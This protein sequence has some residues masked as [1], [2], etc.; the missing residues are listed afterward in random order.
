MEK[1]FYIDIKHLDKITTNAPIGVIMEA[2][3][4]VSLT[5]I[6]KILKSDKHNVK[7]VIIY[8]YYTEN[9]IF[10]DIDNV[11]YAFYNEAEARE[12]LHNLSDKDK[13]HIL[14]AKPCTSGVEILMYKVIG[15][16]NIIISSPLINSIETLKELTHTGYKFFT[17]A[18]LNKTKDGVMDPSWIRPEGIFIYDDC[19]CNYFLTGQSN[20]IDTIV[21]GYLRENGVGFLDNYIKNLKEMGHDFEQVPNMLPITFDEMRANCGAD[22]IHCRGCKRFIDFGNNFKN[23]KES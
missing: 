8:T 16:T 20:T 3:D 7:S 15:I 13:K 22:C 5:E 9:T 4:R 2:I 1:V 23:K 10:Y 18:N 21:N 6:Q 19:I 17:I 11:Y 12:T 14:G